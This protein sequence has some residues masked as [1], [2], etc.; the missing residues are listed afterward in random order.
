MRLV[1]HRRR[2]Q[3][4]TGEAKRWTDES[5]KCGID[6]VLESIRTC[7]TVLGEPGTNDHQKDVS[8]EGEAAKGEK[9]EE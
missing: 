5:R 2:I 7:W 4:E 6:G 3:R 8:E 1:E 9:L